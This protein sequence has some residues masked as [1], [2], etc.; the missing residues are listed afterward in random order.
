MGIDLIVD[1][2][3]TERFCDVVHISVC[4]LVIRGNGA[5]EL[6]YFFAEGGRLRTD[7]RPD[8]AVEPEFGLFFKSD[9]GRTEQGTEQGDGA[10]E[11]SQAIRI[12]HPGH[13][14][15]HEE[16]GFFIRHH[17]LR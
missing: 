17:S 6:E 4:D 9:G 11:V 7:T 14:L 15:M 5:V 3:L 16:P 8:S 13:C 10:G 12:K 1:R 2:G